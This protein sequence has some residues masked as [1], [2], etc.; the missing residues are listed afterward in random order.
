[1]IADRQ[2]VARSALAN[3]LCE[4]VGAGSVTVVGSREE[5]ARV[6][7]RDPAELLVIDDRL[8]ADGTHLLAGLGPVNGVPRTIVVGVDDDPAYAARARRLGAVAWVAKDRADEDLLQLL[9]PP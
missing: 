8:V 5:L 2:G 6:L 1:M 9:D 7:R 3:L 4:R